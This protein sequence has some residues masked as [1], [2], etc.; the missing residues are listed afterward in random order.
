MKT[1][2]QHLMMKTTKARLLFTIFHFQGND[3]VK[4]L[5][6]ST[7]NLSKIWNNV[8]SSVGSFFSLFIDSI[9]S[10]NEYKGQFEIPSVIKRHMKYNRNV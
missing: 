2:M 7:K 5:N 6:S 1:S 4:V 10:L 3:D 8:Y 9:I